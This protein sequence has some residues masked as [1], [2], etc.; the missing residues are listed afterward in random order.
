MEMT[1]GKVIRTLRK[2]K[3]LTIEQLATMVGSDVGNISRLER[4]KQG[5]SD[6]LLQRIASALE[7]HISRI[8]IPDDDPDHALVEGDDTTTKAAHAGHLRNAEWARTKGK[9]PL[10]S[11]VQAGKW[12]EIVDNFQPGDA[13]DWIPCPFTHSKS[14]FILRVVGLSMYN[15]GG[16]KSYAPGEYIA[17]DPE[18]EPMHRKMVVV[19]E[20][21]EEKATFKQLLIDPEG[22]MILQALNPTHVP[23]AMEIP[24]GS[25]IVGTVIG[26]WVPE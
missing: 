16:D 26:K 12:S 23:R 10:I 7:V 9:L 6:A 14:A 19:R 18:G 11:W 1:I 4:D 5:Y 20:G 24:R 17:L 22:T 13:E 21:N 2:Q 25:R 8:F 3:G 15:P